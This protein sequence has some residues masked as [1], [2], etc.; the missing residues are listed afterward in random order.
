MAIE[1][2]WISLLVKEGYLEKRAKPKNAEPQ[3]S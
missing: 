1:P 2:K 3:E